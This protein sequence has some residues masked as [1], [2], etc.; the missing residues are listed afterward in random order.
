[1]RALAATQSRG[2]KDALARLDALAEVSYL[3]DDAGDI[4]AERHRHRHLD[5]WNAVPVPE[6]EVIQSTGAYAQQDFIR[7]E[8]RFGS[9]FVGEDFGSS[10]IVNAN[11]LHLLEYTM[12]RQL[13]VGR[14]PG[15]PHFSFKR[16]QNSLAILQRFRQDLRAIKRQDLS[17][18][19]DNPAV[20]HRILDVRSF[21][22]VD[23]V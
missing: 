2:E 9:I 17:V 10:V 6:V 11:C 13:K 22:S 18:A 15:P 19:H 3:L 16:F 7:F 23:E 1:M 14:I 20:D 5:A 8:F 21:E 12:I 4:A